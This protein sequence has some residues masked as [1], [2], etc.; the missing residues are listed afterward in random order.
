MTTEA[1]ALAAGAPL[2][3]VSLGTAPAFLAFTDLV[4]HVSRPALLEDEPDLPDR[5]RGAV[6]RRLEE[7]VAGSEVFVD[8]ADAA[9]LWTLLFRRDGESGRSEARPYVMRVDF[10]R[11][12][13]RV[14]LRLFGVSANYWKPASVALERALLSGIA[15]RHGGR[16][17]VAMLQ[18]GSGVRSFTG[19]PISRV[20]ERATLHFRTPVALRAGQHTKSQLTSLPLNL[21]ARANALLAWQGLRLAFDRSH[22]ALAQTALR[23]DDFGLIWCRWLRHSS[24]TRTAGIPVGGFVGRLRIE[25]DLAPVWPLLCLGVIIHA[26]SGTAL[27]LGRYDLLAGI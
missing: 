10:D 12:V 20:P 1:R 23:L 7:L 17:R 8:A 4:H 18:T 11:E 2:R 21:V 3:D 9:C 16:Q 14:V 25:G 22:L 5:L 13:I 6:G 24:T 27:G 15:L 26:G 19:I